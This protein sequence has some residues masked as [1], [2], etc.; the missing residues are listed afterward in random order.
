MVNLKTFHILILVT[1]IDINH[2]E[3]CASS[4]VSPGDSLLDPE[5]DYPVSREFPNRLLGDERTNIRKLSEVFEEVINL[6]S[7]YTFIL[8]LFMI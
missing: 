5:N 4:P 6:T 8:L 3:I 2:I 1:V 7:I